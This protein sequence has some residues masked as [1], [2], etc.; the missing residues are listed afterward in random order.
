MG[1]EIRRVPA[2]WEHPRDTDGKYI[3]LRDNYDEALAEFEHDIQARGLRGAIE[4]WG[5]GPR[6]DDY[7]HYGCQPCN[8]YQLYETVSEGTPLSPPFEKPEELIEYLV[9]HGD[10][11]YH[12]PWSQ[13]AAEAMFTP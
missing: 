9:K 8:W 2:Y 13:E 1:R 5:G 6:E 7:T 11:W 3:P 10:F 12:K 4:D